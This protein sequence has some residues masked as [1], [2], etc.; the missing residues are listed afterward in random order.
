MKY[1]KG[2]IVLLKPYEEFNFLLGAGQHGVSIDGR[3]F[4]W[5]PEAFEILGNEVQILEVYGLSQSYMVC[6]K[7]DIRIKNL[8]MSTHHT[9]TMYLIDHFWIKE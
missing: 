7:E 8:N 3:L 2:D 4:L 5:K 6:L 1:N 9:T